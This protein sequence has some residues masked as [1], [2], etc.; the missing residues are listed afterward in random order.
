M[1]N[2]FHH[3]NINYGTESPLRQKLFFVAVDLISVPPI[4]EYRG[5]S[6]GGEMGEFSPPFFLSPLPFFFPY[7]SNIEI[8]FDFSN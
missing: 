1:P 5:G 3:V 7:P 8:I 6:R 2:C 4:R